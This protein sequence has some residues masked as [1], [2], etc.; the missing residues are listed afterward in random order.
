MVQS[1][2]KFAI[3]LPT[4]GVTRPLEDG[5]ISNLT[6]KGLTY[7]KLVTDD[8]VLV[9]YYRNPLALEYDNV[10]T[11]PT[12]NIDEFVLGV[13]AFYKHFAKTPH[14]DFNQVEFVCCSDNTIV[15]VKSIIDLLNLMKLLGIEHHHAQ[16]LLTAAR[17]RYVYANNIHTVGVSYGVTDKEAHIHHLIDS[18]GK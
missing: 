16:G 12:A 5:F 9:Q 4:L 18:F 10:G 6:Q 7:P 1:N 8:Q 2:L 11:K 3:V 17:D 13:Y 14:Y 15:R